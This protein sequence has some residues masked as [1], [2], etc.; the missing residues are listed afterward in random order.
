MN[1]TEIV[2]DTEITARKL[3]NAGSRYTY[4]DGTAQ[5][6]CAPAGPDGTFLVF[7]DGKVYRVTVAETNL[8]EDFEDE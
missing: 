7:R 1:K 4:K 8:G 2:S 6:E 3:S 5:M